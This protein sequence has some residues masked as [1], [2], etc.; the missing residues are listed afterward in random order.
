MAE[1]NELIE[2]FYVGDKQ[3][4]YYP[5]WPVADVVRE[6]CAAFGISCESDAEDYVRQRLMAR[7]GGTERI[8]QGDEIRSFLEAQWRDDDSG[9]IDE[10][11]ARDG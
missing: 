7:P 10:D 5:G 9:L 3:I 2:G 4:P 8:Q 6:Q 11:P 1:A